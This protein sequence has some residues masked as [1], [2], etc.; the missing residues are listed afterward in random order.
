MRSRSIATTLALVAPLAACAGGGASPGSMAG[1]P[2]LAYAPPP[3]GAV[4][5][6]QGDTIEMEIDAG[7]Q[8]L[9]VTVAMSSVL[10]VTYAGGGDEI[11]VTIDF[12]EFQIDAS[13]PMAGSQRG[14]ESEIDGPVVFSMDR[15]G[16]GTLI[17]SPEVDGVAEQAVSPQS[18]AASFFP[19]LPGRAVTAG[20]MWTDTV[21]L[22]ID[23]NAGSTEGT[24][25]YE[26]TAVGDTVVDGATYL[27]VAFTSDDDRRQETVQDGA[28]ITQDVGGNGSGWYL[29]DSG[30]NLVV[31]QFLQARLRGSME[32]SMAPVPLGLD[33][34]VVQHLRLDDGGDR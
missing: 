19:R 1:P 12:R 21:T 14:D 26:F 27:K 32:V 4:T 9:D 20:E 16:V 7:G 15:R 11:E 33:M 34:V 13:N 18:M 10:D 25:I 29:W 2:A 24:T 17:A 30:R 6:L 8:M 3:G 23:E 31:E 28:R 22:D 5:Y